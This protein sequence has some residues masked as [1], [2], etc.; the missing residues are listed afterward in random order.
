MSSAERK[1]L[2]GGVAPRPRTYGHR[3]G[4]VQKHSMSRADHRYSVAEQSVKDSS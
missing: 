1:W 4:V 3:Q 2:W